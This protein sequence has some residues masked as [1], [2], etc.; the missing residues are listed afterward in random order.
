MDRGLGDLPLLP[1]L[2]YDSRLSGT[3][4]HG[5]LWKG[6]R[7]VE[8]TGFAPVLSTLV[9]NADPSTNLGSI[10]RVAIIP[11]IG[12]R[13]VPGQ[14]SPTCRPVDQELNTLTATAAEVAKANDT[15]DKFS[16][17]RRYQ[18]IDLEALYFNDSVT[19]GNNCDRTGPT[20]GTGPYSGAYHLLSGAVIQFAVPASD[21]AGVWRVVVVYTDNAT[22]AQGNGL[23][24]PLD[25]AD[26]GTGV[27]R[28]GAG[29]ASGRRVTYVIQAVDNRGNVTWLEYQSAVPPASG[30]PP[31]LALPI[32][33]NVP[34][35]PAVTVTGFLP[36]GG[37]VGTAVTV[38]GTG[39]SGATRVALNGLA[40]SFLVVGDREILLQ[41]PFG[42]SSG[43]IQVTAPGGTGTSAASFR[44]LLPSATAVGSSANPSLLGQSVT[45]TAT[46]TPVSGGG[47]PTGTVQFQADGTSLGSPV[48]LSGGGASV[49][50]SSLAAGAHVVTAL[51]GGDGTFA[52]SAGTLAG[53]QVVQPGLAG[54][55]LYTVAPCR[56]IDTRTISP[57]AMAPGE[58]RD[59]L[60]A[61]GCAISATAG[62]IALNVTVDSPTASG[63]LTLFPGGLATP[64]GTSV[65]SFRQGAVR[66]S[67]AIMM[68]G[69]NGKLGI[70]NVSAGTTHVIVDVV[71]YFE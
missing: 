6:G 48:T 1:Y 33:V 8:E 2:V 12:N 16:I 29:V 3:S 45:F 5:I 58:R 20:L 24:T 25:L 7:Y 70:A 34:T 47:T 37:A 39:F 36:A 64:P 14:D 66:A 38:A 61:G 54:D 71:G 59:F 28:G 4:Q 15:D 60:A 62:A 56:L 22:D 68:L 52:S 35:L 18:T 10:A 30:I 42:A 26:D 67:N 51:Y 11:P 55:R 44:V 13:L 46:V 63:Y 21:A 40:T 65:I 23:W 49:A 69:A 9:S 53:G 57:P 43:P 32:D 17:H 19:P 41:V 27:F 50:T 31:G